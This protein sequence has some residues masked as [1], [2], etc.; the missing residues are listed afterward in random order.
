MISTAN[1]PSL[2][3]T[4]KD[5]VTGVCNGLNVRFRMFVSRIPYLLRI[6]Y[7]SKKRRYSKRQKREEDTTRTTRL[8]SFDNLL[9][10]PSNNQPNRIV[11]QPAC[12]NHWKDRT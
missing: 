3:S 5:G 8:D 9:A 11:R 2:L 10:R 6:K 7:S 4:N 12:I 1:E